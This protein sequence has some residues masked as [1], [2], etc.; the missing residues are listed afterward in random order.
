MFLKA[1]KQNTGMNKSMSKT[2]CRRINSVKDLLYFTLFIV[3][4]FIYFFIAMSVLSLMFVNFDRQWVQ[5]DLIKNINF[6]KLKLWHHC[7]P[8]YPQAITG[9]TFYLCWP[10][11]KNIGNAGLFL[12]V[13]FIIQNCYIIQF[14][15]NILFVNTSRAMFLVTN[16]VMSLATGCFSYINNNNNNTFTPRPPPL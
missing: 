7:N 14:Y 6:I 1:I 3:T 8:T 13:S 10:H 12:H 9:P 15:L 4:D 16:F 11:C 5:T 2:F